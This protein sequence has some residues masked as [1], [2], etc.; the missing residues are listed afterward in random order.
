M[1][2]HVFTGLRASGA[3]SAASAIETAD[4]SAPKPVDA[5]VGGARV[6]TMQDRLVGMLP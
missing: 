5:D 2:M 3:P 4:A 1:A 6:S